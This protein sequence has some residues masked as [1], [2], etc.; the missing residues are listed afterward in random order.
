[1]YDQHLST[2]RPIWQVFFVF[3][4]KNFQERFFLGNPPEAPAICKLL[5]KKHTSH[6]HHLSEAGA[7][8]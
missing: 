7:G 2:A 3:V 1:M 4:I 5:Y 6:S 8:P